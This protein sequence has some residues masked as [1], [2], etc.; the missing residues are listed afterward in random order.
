[1]EKFLHFVPRIRIKEYRNTTYTIYELYSPNFLPKQ[2]TTK[3]SIFTINDTSV[4]ILKNFNGLNTYEEIVSKLS[5]KYS[6]DKNS[7]SAKVNTFI[8]QLVNEYGYELKEESEPLES[9]IDYLVYANNYPSVASV[10]LTNICNLCCRHCY[11]T[12]GNNM[13][14]KYMTLNELTFLIKSLGEMGVEI[15]ELTGGDPTMNPNSN[16]AIELAFKFGI[17]TVIYLTNGVHMSKELVNTLKNYRDKIFVQIDLHSLNE[18]YYNWFTGTENNLE[19]VKTHI[20][21]LIDNGIRVRVCTII[22]PGNVYELEKIGEWAYSHGAIQFAPSVVTA[23]G[24]A[25]NYDPELFFQDL[26]TVNEYQKQ[27]NQILNHH[28]GFIQMIEKLESITRKNCGALTS[29]VSINCYGDIKLCSMDCREFFK[30]KLDNALTY[31]IKNIYDKNQEL[32]QKLMKL[33]LPQIDSEECQNCEQKLFCSNCI[34]RGIAGAK[35]RIAYGKP[36]GWY[37][38]IDLDI[39]DKLFT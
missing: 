38:K 25:D 12:F 17:Q 9:D 4:E 31:P 13:N 24:R 34:L 15:L 37:N 7:I 30:F 5:E 18:T 39:K 32:L 27:H 16:K 14:E 28:P 1:M 20:D 3:N 2:T 19:K 22:T 21:Q 35:K 8:G 11:G 26:A 36:C 33:E 29:Q 10:E 23:L 6:E